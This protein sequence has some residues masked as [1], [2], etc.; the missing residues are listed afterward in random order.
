MVMSPEMQFLSS[1]SGSL[2]VLAL[3][4]L[5]FGLTLAWA[6]RP[7]HEDR[8][9]IFAAA[10]GAGLTLASINVVALLAG[11]WTGAWTGVPLIATVALC[12]LAGTGGFAL[13]LGLYRWLE[14][15]AHHPLRVYTCIVLLFIPVVL[16]ADPIQIQRGWFQFSGGYTIWT[17]VL[18]GQVVM[19]MP[20]LLYEFLKRRGAGTAITVRRKSV[21]PR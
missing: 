1:P 7:G 11:W 16:F 12:A 13:W 3:S 21:K 17:D 9:L 15:R 10:P 6:T 8:R 18:L 4:P 2:I 14:R 5:I 20:A 19:W